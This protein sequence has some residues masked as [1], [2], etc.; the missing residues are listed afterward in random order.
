MTGFKETRTFEHV[1][2]VAMD[3]FRAAYDVR[4]QNGR[5]NGETL[6]D[7]INQCIQIFA[8]PGRPL[9]WTPDGMFGRLRTRRVPTEAYP[10]KGPYEIVAVRLY[11]ATIV[12][13]QSPRFALGVTALAAA[14][15]IAPYVCRPGTLT[16]G[17]TAVMT[18]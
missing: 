6:D 10:V 12:K 3:A 14:S 18:Y 17:Q 4:R 2:A 9:Y 5:T 11:P 1:P 15:T 16:D 7:I 8:Y 13:L